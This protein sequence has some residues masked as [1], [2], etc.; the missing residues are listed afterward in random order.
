M[1]AFS[2]IPSN[3][4]NPSPRA[5]P[6]PSSLF[7]LS[8]HLQT[9]PLKCFRPKKLKII[10]CQQTFELDVKT[11]SAKK[12]PKPRPSF[13]EQVQSKWSVK[14]PSL[15]QTFPWQQQ[16][17]SDA[18]R[19]SQPP[20]TSL[21]PSDVS[22][23]DRGSGHISSVSEPPVNS[24]TR[25]KST[26]APWAHGKESRKKVSQEPSARVV[27][28]SDSLRND[29]SR[30]R[31]YNE[32]PICPPKK[33]VI[34]G[35]KVSENA[36]AVEG[37]SITFRTNKLERLPWE[38]RNEVER[39]K[40]D[41]LRNRNTVLAERV[42]PEHELKRL[43]NVSLRMAEHIK[44]GSA[45]VTQTLV[46]TIQE[47]WK[48]EEV[49]KLKFEG[50][51]SKNMKRTHEFLESRTGGL[52]IYRS[53]GLVV[54]Y[55][56]SSY[57]LDCV[58][59]YGERAQADN[60]ELSSAGEDFCESNKAGRINGAA[61][62]SG[63]C[64]LSYVNNLSKQEQMDLHEL[65]SMLDELGPRF[66]DWSGREPIPVD[67]DLLPTVVP[68]YKTPFRLLPHG[69][70]H[71]LRDKEM[72]FLRRT[73][74]MVPPHF[75]L[76]R[77]RE[78]QGLAMAMVKLWEKSAIAKIAIKR[79]VLNTSN[80]RMAEQLKILTGGTLVSRNKE[81][82]VFYRG[83]DFLPPRVSSALVEAEKVAALQ[84]D[85][86]EQA[87]EKASSL[88]DPT[89][90]SR[91]RLV[92]GTLSETKAATSRWGSEPDSAALEKMKR[93]TA[94]ARHASL[95][96]SLEKKLALAKGKIS[97][98]EKVLQ[99]VLENQEPEDL[100]TDLETLTDEERFLFRKIGLSMKPFLHLGRR[101]I[102]D[103]TIENM[104][105][106]WKYRELVKIMVERKTL[107]QVKH[108]AISLEAESGG[109]LVCVER[110]H[111][112]HV[113]IVYRG[114][115]YQRPLAFRPKNLLTK[116]QALA[117]SIELQR[118]EALKHHVLELEENLEKLKKGLEDAMMAT[119]DDSTGNLDSRNGTE[120]LQ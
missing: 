44:V 33:N 96:N 93:D 37:S 89:R 117:R 4:L 54:L 41:K 105:L 57:K 90:E 30:G 10:C 112:G 17:I 70:R 69:V 84:Q 23:S 118:R 114:K 51:P 32:T 22:S 111:K 86:E 109:V 52:V 108:I 21:S 79:G 104:H 26:M 116:R 18:S 66:V 20:P 100:P 76:G 102:F 74:R 87:R 97:R 55:R 46:D 119:D 11:N 6:P 120:R 95:V 61:K 25:I 35:A 83:N 8:F 31:D 49:V 113:I 72:T 13:V 81:F 106:H 75:A 50:P 38:R 47:K 56:G 60:Q 62:S 65:N 43:R 12:K 101:E 82:I 91:Q 115:N 107:S 59:S 110:T 80:E 34:L 42:M 73:A 77:N 36:T 3:F 58:K 63:I 28:G 99:K 19:E 68:G 45:G 67:A 24:R 88:L 48:H 1:T 14:T 27:Q 92:A 71:A 85:E 98:A 9:H 78:L 40:E 103:G 53:G 64:N 16:K 7:L 29:G 2:P 15:R 94:V 5:S 39:V